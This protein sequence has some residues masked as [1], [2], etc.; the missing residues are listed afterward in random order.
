M[1]EKRLIITVKSDAMTPGTVLRVI[2]LETV[3][4][5]I[6]VALDDI[7]ARAY[8]TEARRPYM[9]SPTDFD[10]EVTRIDQDADLAKAWMYL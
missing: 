4:K 6:R 1:D 8:M 3:A 10:V 7:T 5:A 9:G 2:S